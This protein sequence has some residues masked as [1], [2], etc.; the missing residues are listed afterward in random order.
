MCKFPALSCIFSLKFSLVCSVWTS[1][2][3]VAIED[4]VPQSY[5]IPYCVFG[6]LS[7]VVNLIVLMSRA[8]HALWL[9]HNLHKI[10]SSNESAHSESEL[11]AQLTWGATLGMFALFTCPIRLRTAPSSVPFESV[12]YGR[13]ESELARSDVSLTRL[14]RT[15]HAGLRPFDPHIRRFCLIGDWRAAGCSNG[16]PQLEPL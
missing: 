6:S 8:M 1:Y 11:I 3:V 14:A 7:V 2:K 13:V 5:R 4:F 12:V 15:L 10:V 9:R 16:A